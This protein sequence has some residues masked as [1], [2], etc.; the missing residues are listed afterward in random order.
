MSEKKK[1]ETRT[2]FPEADST[3]RIILATDAMGMGVGYRKVELVIQWG[4]EKFVDDDSAVKTVVQ[5]FGGSK[6]VR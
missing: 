2:D 6:R 5:R 1:S 3:S 4:V